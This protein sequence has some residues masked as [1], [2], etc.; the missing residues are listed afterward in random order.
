MLKSVAEHP[1]SAGK[2]QSDGPVLEWKGSRQSIEGS[3][4]QHGS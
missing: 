2:P 4:Q 1:L 3:E